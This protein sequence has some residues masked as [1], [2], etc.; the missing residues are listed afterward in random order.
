MPDLQSIIQ[1]YV[2][3]LII[4]YSDPTDAGVG[5]KWDEGG[6]TWDGTGTWDSGSQTQNKAQAT[7]ASM[8][9]NILANNIFLQIQA[10]YNLAGS[11]GGPG[12]TWDEPGETWDSGKA[13]DTSVSDIAL[14]KQLDVLGKYA[15]VDRFYSVVDLENYFSFI[16][17]DEV[18][19]L[20]SSP[21]RFGFNT[22]A[23]FLNNNYNGTLDYSDII[24]IG[25]SLTDPNFL[26][27]IQLAIIQNNSNFSH[28]ELDDAL[29]KFFGTSI[30]MESSNHMDLIYFV[31]S[32]M[33]PIISAVLYKK[34]LPHPMAVGSSIVTGITGPMFG[35]ADYSG[36]FSPFASGFSTYSNYATLPGQI[37]TYRQIAKA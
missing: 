20:P 2:Q 10:A 24:S 3:L 31:A 29:V 9:E 26:T 30:R 14:G 27:I 19:S 32:S 7:I 11:T 1:Y 18:L 23:T 15:G 33:T 17:Y 28:K 36:Y 35:F 4:Q 8:A 34:L 21:P 37:L 16:T 12:G 22:Y 5:L 6:L 25:N 13:W